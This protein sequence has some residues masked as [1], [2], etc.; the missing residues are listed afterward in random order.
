MEWRKPWARYGGVGLIP[1]SVY[2]CGGCY[3]VVFS[4]MVMLASGVSARECVSNAKLVLKTQI[5]SAWTAAESE[6]DDRRS[7]LF[8]G[9]P[10]LSTS[11]KTLCMNLFTKRS[12]S[13]NVAL[14]H[15]CCWWK[16]ERL[17]WRRE[18]HAFTLISLGDCTVGI[19][20]W[21]TLTITLKQCWLLARQAGK[22]GNYNRITSSI[23]ETTR[24]GTIWILVFGGSFGPRGRTSNVGGTVGGVPWC[25]RVLRVVLSCGLGGSALLPA[26]KLLVLNKK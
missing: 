4:P 18:M 6:P 3:T 13:I 1:R 8:F 11:C 17:P 19:I 15:W 16:L 10:A 24:T 26:M 12:R 25:F 2:S 22:H 23:K 5:T 14:V 9:T 7:K 21:G 20:Y